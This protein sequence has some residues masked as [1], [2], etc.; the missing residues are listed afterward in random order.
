MAGNVTKEVEAEGELI[1]HNRVAQQ[2]KDKEAELN[3]LRA[4]KKALCQ[5]EAIRQ[6]ENSARERLR[7]ADAEKQSLLREIARLERNVKDTTDGGERG[8]R[9][10]RPWIPEEISDTEDGS[11]L[12]GV[13][14]TSPLSVELQ[15]ESWPVGYRPR[16]P[17][18]DGKSDPR[19]F[20]ASFEAAVHSAG[21]D[22]T[23]LAKSLIMAVEDIAHEWYIGIEP[24]SIES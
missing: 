17:T 7:L 13:N 23:T 6:S 1:E 5:Q 24:L 22:S 16:L 19:K 10:H 12:E 8:L 14:D 21:G 9:V 11:D 20:I 15:M 2:L 4:R 3:E 18:Y